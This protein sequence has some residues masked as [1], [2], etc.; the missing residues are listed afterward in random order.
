VQAEERAP[1]TVRDG[2]HVVRQH[3]RLA[4]V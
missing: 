4:G 2:I 1:E 3:E